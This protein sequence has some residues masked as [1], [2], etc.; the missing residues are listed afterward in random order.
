MGVNRDGYI[1]LSGGK[2]KNMEHGDPFED[3][4]LGVRI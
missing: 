3:L 2:E 4:S 1:V